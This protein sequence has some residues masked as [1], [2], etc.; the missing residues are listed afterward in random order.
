MFIFKPSNSRLSDF[1]FF[2]CQGEDKKKIWFS[3]KFPEGEKTITIS[4]I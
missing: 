1:F 3:I 4:P 2:F